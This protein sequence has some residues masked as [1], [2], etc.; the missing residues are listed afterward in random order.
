MV[1]RTASVEPAAAM[2]KVERPTA[3][4]ATRPVGAIEVPALSTLAALRVVDQ[5]TIVWGQQPAVVALPD[6]EFNS[7]TVVPLLS[8][9]LTFAATGRVGTGQQVSK[10]EVSNGNGSAGM[11]ASVGRWLAAQGLPVSSLTDQRPY[12]QVQT[13]VQF[14]NGHAEAAMRVA[15]SL[16]GDGKALLVPT[17]GLRA[18]VRVVLGHDWAPIKACLTRDACHPAVASVIRRGGLV[19]LQD[20]DFPG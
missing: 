3:A 4:G 15:R 20:R 13:L 12:T 6:A 1:T 2:I 8:V 10:L 18:D 7:P 17:Q 14:R 19:R 11:A 9:A 16:P 5:P